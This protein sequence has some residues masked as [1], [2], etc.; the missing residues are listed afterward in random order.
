MNRVSDQTVEDALRLDLAEGDAMVDMLAPILRHLLVNDDRSLFSDETVA[1]VRGMIDD[2]ARQLLRAWDA[3]GEVDT[4]ENV[5]ADRADRLAGLLLGNAPLLAHLHA[6]ATE[7]QLA[8][9]LQAETGLDPVLSP[10]LQ[11]L[12]SSNESH[13]AETAM[14][15]LAAQARF[16]Q[17]VRRMELPITEL[18]GDHFHFVLTAMQAISDQDE[19]SVQAEASLRTA[20]DESR[21]RLGLIAQL[22][23]GMGG[24]AIAA[25]SVQ[26]AG[27]GIFLSALAIASA[28]ERDLAVLSTNR[29]LHPRLALSLCAT[30]LKPALVLEQVAC[31]DPDYDLPEEF[32]S[33]R[34][35]RAVAL[36]TAST[37][38]HPG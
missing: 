10:L 24:G 22:V 29:R 18:P 7:W 11:A 6:L 23:T 30:G 34:P 1:R 25:L 12:I 9:R 8:V 28:Q 20:F 21:S 31:L 3:S 33:L 38:R 37:A 2:I 16:V 19:R 14:A 35:D 4:G 26:H 15:A 32:L 36:L 17:S 13:T 27:V 5:S